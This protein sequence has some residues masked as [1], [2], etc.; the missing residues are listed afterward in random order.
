M[1]WTSKSGAKLAE[2]LREMG[3]EVVDRTVLRLL[4]ANGFLKAN[5]KTREGA[6][7]P[8][9]DAQFAQISQTAAAAITAGPLVISV[10]NDDTLSQL[11]SELRGVLTGYPQRRTCA[12]RRGP[13]CE[14]ARTRVTASAGRHRGWLD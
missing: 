7:H 1:R 10:D 6:S 4:K 14:P 5:C 11:P 2:A 13:R 9:R 12:R 3:H 8:D